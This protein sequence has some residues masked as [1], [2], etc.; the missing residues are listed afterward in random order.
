VA[1]MILAEVV[2][3]NIGA[4]VKVMDSNEYGQHLTYFEICIGN[5]SDMPGKFL[6]R[7]FTNFNFT[8][9]VHARGYGYEL[10]NKIITVHTHIL[11]WYW[12]KDFI[13]RGV[14]ERAI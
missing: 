2:V 11:K 8:F 14:D 4:R 10:Q 9:G 13:K 5:K 3:L 6:K 12:H 1:E 7:V